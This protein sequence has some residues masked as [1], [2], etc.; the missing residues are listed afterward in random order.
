MSKLTRE[1][2]EQKVR[3]ARERYEKAEL[4]GVVLFLANLRDTHLFLEHDVGS[5]V[6]EFE[7]YEALMRAGLSACERANLSG[8][9]PSRVDPWTKARWFPS[10]GA[11]LSGVDLSG[12][13]LSGVDLREAYLCKADLSGS[14][15]SRANL[16]GADLHRAN[17]TEANLSGANLGETNLNFVH[18]EGVDLRE[19]DLSGADLVA[20][21]LHRADLNGTNFNGTI[22]G[23]TKFRD[24]DL[25]MAKAL[26][27]VKHIR[28][29]FIDV[30]VI[31]Y[32][33]TSDSSIDFDKIPNKV[34]VF[35]QRAGV[36]VEELK[37][38]PWPPPPPEVEEH[39]LNSRLGLARTRLK[40][41]QENRA[42]LEEQQ[43]YYEMDVSLPLETVLGLNM[44]EIE[45]F[46]AK[47][48][49]IET[50]LSNLDTSKK[51]PT[52]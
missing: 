2:V 30:D 51:A 33:P 50:K 10:H 41:L 20:A 3:E 49:D 9:D 35:L 45:I 6:V 12:V 37:L 43:G 13:N 27:T 47:I 23:S 52:E 8:V 4:S 17:L 29:S 24:V 36:R 25:R 42:V 40:R 34:K 14:N 1:Q 31:S 22:V 16:T 11:Y 32:L 5:K 21:Y 39:W 38:Y 18:L 19:A 44:T 48:S 46:Q 28:P 15:L 7:D 26:D